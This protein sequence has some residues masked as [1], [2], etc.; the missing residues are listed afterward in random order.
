MFW[1]ETKVNKFTVRIVVYR[2]RSSMNRAIKKNFATDKTCLGFCGWLGDTVCLIFNE[3]DLNHEILAHEIYH[4]F[5]YF[6]RRKVKGLKLEEDRALS[7]GFL[8]QGIY[9]YLKSENITI[10]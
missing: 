6:K 1:G 7:L 3:Q 10:S 5:E 9:E 4:A 2:T 8:T